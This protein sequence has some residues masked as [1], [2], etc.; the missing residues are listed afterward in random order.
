MTNC[1]SELL[2][3]SYF[4]VTLVVPLP[5]FEL[6]CLLRLSQCDHYMLG[7]WGRQLGFLADRSLD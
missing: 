2:W 6:E 5:T 7:V 3:T 1:I 4:S